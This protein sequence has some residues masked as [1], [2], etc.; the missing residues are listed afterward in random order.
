MGAFAELADLGPILC[1]EIEADFTT[2]ATAFT[3]V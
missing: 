3:P 1:H 2:A